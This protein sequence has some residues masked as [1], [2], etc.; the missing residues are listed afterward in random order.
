MI[1]VV[2]ALLVDATV[3]GYVHREADNGGYEM[4]LE[5]TDTELP[6]ARFLATKEEAAQAHPRRPGPPEDR[7]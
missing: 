7:R 1:V 5:R 6:P 4:L 3:W 2:T